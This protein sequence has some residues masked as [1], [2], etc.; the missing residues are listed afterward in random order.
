M[1]AIHLGP[2]SIDFSTKVPIV[3]GLIFMACVLPF[4]KGLVGELLAAFERWQAR[5]RL[6]VA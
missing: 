3:I 2:L 4:R 5:R 6:R 1:G